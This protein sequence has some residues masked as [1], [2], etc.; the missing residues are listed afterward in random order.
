M[1]DENYKC[2]ELQYLT[3]DT[4]DHGVAFGRLLLGSA[5]PEKHFFL[6]LPVEGKVPALRSHYALLREEPMAALE[7]HLMRLSTQGML[8]RSIIHFGTCCDP[9]W[10]FEGRFDVSMKF[11][12]LFLRYTP[13]MLIVQTRSPLVV[14]A[15]PVLKRLNARALVNIAIESPLDEVVSRYTPG[16]PRI[17]E[18]FRVCTALR[19]LGVKVGIQVAPVLPYGDFRED[20]HSFANAICENCDH[21]FLG[22]LSD[23]SEKEER[24]MRASLLAKSLARDRQYFW[25]RP[26]STAP[27]KAAISEIA[28][29]KLIMPSYTHLIARQQTL[30]LG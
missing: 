1:I 5:S 19:R 23:G 13:G 22:P 29:E 2:G 14:L 16:L 18:R 4:V 24:Q 8:G 15:M 26:D 28:P 9:F 6:R 12:Q 21:V 3:V 20:A 27:L 17:G 7:R 11:L 25:L 30:R 10:P